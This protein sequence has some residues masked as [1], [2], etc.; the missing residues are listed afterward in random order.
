[1]IGEEKMLGK[2]P[3]HDIITS[4]MNLEGTLYFPN[5]FLKLGGTGD[6]FGNQVIAGSLQIQG[7]GLAHEI[8]TM[9][10]APFLGL[11]RH[12]RVDL[13]SQKIFHGITK[14]VGSHG[15]DIHDLSIGGVQ[16]Q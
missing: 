8:G 3:G 16:D 14:S 5:N 4:D 13:F 6:G 2:H 7:T 10:R 15:I 9:K 12:A 11:G 1:M